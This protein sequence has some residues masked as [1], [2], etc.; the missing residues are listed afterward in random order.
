MNGGGFLWE[1]GRRSFWGSSFHNNIVITLDERARM[2]GEWASKRTNE[3][4]TNFC[5]SNHTYNGGPQRMA[6]NEETTRRLNLLPHC[7]QPLIILVMVVDSHTRALHC[8]GAGELYC[9]HNIQFGGRGSIM[10]LLIENDMILIRQLLCATDPK[11][12]SV[13]SICT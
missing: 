7:P 12:G 10:L 3:R 1:K 13:D 8:M 6:A 9:L 2:I 4:T 11:W 5:V